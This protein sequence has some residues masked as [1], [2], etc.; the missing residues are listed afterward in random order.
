VV[1]T[2]AGVRH[3]VTAPFGVVEVPEAPPARQPE[4]EPSEPSPR[5]AQH[6][7][8]L[9]ANLDGEF[10]AAFDETDVGDTVGLLRIERDPIILGSIDNKSVEGVTRAGLRG[11]HSCFNPAMRKR[12]FLSG[13]ITIRFVVDPDGTVSQAAP[14]TSTLDNQAVETCLAKRF[15]DLVFPM[16]R[17]SGIAIISMPLSAAFRGEIEGRNV[18]SRHAPSPPLNR[19]AAHNFGDIFSRR[20]SGTVSERNTPALFGDGAIDTIPASAIEALAAT[21]YPDFPGVSG[22]VPH[23]VD[24]NVARFGWKGDTASLIAFVHGA[25]ANEL[26]LQ[27]PTRD[28]PGQPGGLDIEEP[29]V[30]ALADFV[31]DLPSP[32][33]ALTDPGVLEGYSH[34]TEQGCATCHTPQVSEVEGLFSDLLLH[35]MGRALSSDGQGY[36]SFGFSRAT[37]KRKATPSEWRTPPLWGLRDSAPYMHDGR[38]RTIA[39]AILAHDG[40]A[41]ASRARFVDA[42]PAQREATITFLKSLRAPPGPS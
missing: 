8:F 3:R 36:G 32:V 7:R 10:E 33:M 15:T 34:F 28:Q 16:P 27:T 37:I 38:A 9:Q 39:Q 5:Q 6:E 30:Q 18:Q 42:T 25:C 23:D 41:A 35:D 20:G 1:V 31:S 17:A 12:H 29:E 22:R 13:K 4:E 26:G 2:S 14:K 11:M 24:G 40:E 21:S 19:A